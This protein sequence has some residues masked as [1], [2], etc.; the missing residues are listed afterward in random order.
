MGGQSVCVSMPCGSM[1]FQR[2]ISGSLLHAGQRY[3]SSG[4]PSSPGG[5]TAAGAWREL[6]WSC[7]MTDCSRQD[8]SLASASS[9]SCLYFSQSLQTTSFW[10]AVM[11]PSRSQAGAFVCHSPAY[12]LCSF[13]IVCA[14]VSCPCELL[15]ALHVI[16]LPRAHELSICYPPPPVSPADSPA[17]TVSSLYSATYQN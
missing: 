15:T 6:T 7:C 17:S 10:T 16:C 2:C 4:L 11:L 8:T 13:T 5:W 3:A 1:S 9:P 12:L 14:M